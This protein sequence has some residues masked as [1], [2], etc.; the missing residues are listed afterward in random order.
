MKGEAVKAV[1]GDEKLQGPIPPELII[2]QILSEATLTD[3]K[4]SNGETA[5]PG[6]TVPE[7]RHAEE[8]E[9]GKYEELELLSRRRLAKHVFNIL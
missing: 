9:P 7:K 2:R 3:V 5:G 4:S 6:Q 1:D 8:R